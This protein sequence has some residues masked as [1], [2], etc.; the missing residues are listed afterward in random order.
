[1]DV[2]RGE[3]A[4]LESFREILRH[5][6]DVRL[7]DRAFDADDMG[8]NLPGLGA[9]GVRHRGGSAEGRSADGDNTRTECA[10]AHAKAHG[11]HSHYL[12]IP[13][14]RFFLLYLRE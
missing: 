12:L 7:A 13:P 11:S 14:W 10:G 5:L 1:M 3:A 8:K 4:G 9:H 2:S 6:R